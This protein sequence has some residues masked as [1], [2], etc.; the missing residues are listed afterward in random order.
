MYNDIRILFY[1]FS[2]CDE[3]NK[4]MKNFMDKDFLLS[5]PAGV[6]LFENYAKNTPIIDY[7]CHLIPAEIASNKQFSNITEAWL[8]GDHYKWRAIR[9]SGYEEKFITGGEGVSDYDRF[10]AWAKTMP[11]LVG[12]PLYHWTHLELQRFFDFYEPLSEKT[13]DKA[14]EI[15]N[16]KLASGQMRAKDLITS[17]NVKVV[18]T[19]DDPADSLEYH[20][21]IAE[22]ADFTTKVYPAFRPDKAVNIDKNG[23]KEYITEKLC[24]AYGSKIENI[25]ELCQ[26]FVNRLDFFESLGCKTSDHGIDYVPFAVCDKKTADKIFKKAMKGKAVTTLEADQYKTYMLAFFASEFTKRDWVMQIH[27]GV[28][29]NNS[30][31]YFAKL[32][33]DTGFDS[34]SGHD[35]I[36]NILG[37][38]NYF[39]K[40]ESLPKMVFYSLNPGENALI[41]MAVGC[42]Q[43]ND[44]GIKSKI[45]HGSAW[46]VNDHLEGMRDQLKSFA[47][48]G[49]LANFVG[50]LTDSRSFLSYPRHEYFRRIL[51]DYIGRMIDNGEYGADM[52]TA[53][54]IITDISFNN[55][56]KFF[57]FNA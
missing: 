16:A 40:N 54:K 2:G 35:C 34:I 8:Y 13:A 32:G 11:G 44:K 51:C 6:E 12:N 56:N 48:I 43:G 18:C 9:A 23:F 49:V 41:D 28:A 38:L 1:H 14:W 47:S 26:C 55:A 57:G 22:D 27:Y 37:I 30:D 36:R 24:V 7:H 53:G 15:C 4:H 21:Q 25:D 5:T 46:W 52:E 10:L 17:S 33:P 50:M 39:E 42:F 19:T 20:K 3:R 31:K 45:Q 29:R